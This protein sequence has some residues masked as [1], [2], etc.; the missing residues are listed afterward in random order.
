MKE[1]VPEKF[2][3]VRI[4]VTFHILILSPLLLIN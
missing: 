4:A 2:L 3:F 1:V